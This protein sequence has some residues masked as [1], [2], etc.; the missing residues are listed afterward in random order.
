[1]LRAGR[2]RNCKQQACYFTH[3]TADTQSSRLRDVIEG[4]KH[5]KQAGLQANLDRWRNPI[6]CLQ[7]VKPQTSSFLQE[8]NV[9]FRF[10]PQIFCFQELSVSPHP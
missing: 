10:Y 5:N 9:Q 2:S 1:M 4:Q 8:A 3:G 7:V 6:K